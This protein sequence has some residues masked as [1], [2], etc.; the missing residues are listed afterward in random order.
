[1]HPTSAGAA[2]TVTRARRGRAR[3]A[4]L[5]TL[6]LL[7][8]PLALI[9]GSSPAGAAQGQQGAPQVSINPGGGVSL[10]GD[11][12]LK[13]ILNQA[14]G[15]T[16]QDQVWFAN[17][18]Q[19]CCTAGAPM[20]NIGGELF[21]QSGPAYS[22]SNWTSLTVG[23]TTGSTTTSNGTATGSGSVQLTYVA[24]K[25][26]LT[27]TM[28]RTVSYTYPN[29][30]FSDSYSFTIPNGNT[31][32]VKFYLGGDTAPGSSDQGYGIMLTSPVRSVISLNTSSQIQFGYRE[33]GGERAFDG[34]RSGDYWEP[35]AWVQA[36]QDIPFHVDAFD[37][38]AGLMVQWN[39]GSTPGT[40]TGKL[41]QFVTYQ[42][43]SL[44]AQFRHASFDYTTE[45]PFDFNLTNT[46][47]TSAVGQGFTFAFPNGM[48]IGSGSQTNGCGGTVT[49][50]AGSSTVTMSGVDVVATS[51]CVLTIPV[52][53]A[54]PG[55]YA[56]STSSVS[57]L[58]GGIVNRV[59]NSTAAVTSST[60]TPPAWVDET[61][62]A[63]TQGSYYND[64]LVASGW[65]LP[66]FAVTAGTL[67][68]GLSLDTAT[69]AITGTPTT[70]GA[71]S[72]SITASNGQGTDLV[73]S[74]SGTVSGTPVAPSWSDQTLAAP[75]VDVAY[76]DGVAASGYPAVTY[77][78]SAG[79][80]PAG[81]SL[82]ANTGAVTGTPTTPGAY[83]FTIQASNGV[84]SPVTRAFS[85]TVSQ[86]PSF[87]DETLAPFQEGT[88]YADGLSV[89]ATP[90][91]TYTV[92]AGALP[93]GI[94][95]DANTG[96][97]TGTPTAVG[98]YSFTI[99]VSNG[100]APDLVK[101][102]TG[103][104]LPAVPPAVGIDLQLEIGAEPGTDGA[105]ALV[106]G[107]GMLPGSPY[108]VVMHS[109][110]IVLATG[111]VGGDGTFSQY[112]TIP[113]NAPAGSHTL[114]VTGT[115]SAGDPMSD[116]A[117]FAI[118][119]NGT[120]GDV[121]TDVPLSS[122]LGYAGLT[123]ARVLDTRTADP[124]LPFEGG[125]EHELVVVGVGGVP[126]DA[127]SVQLNVTVTGGSSAG[128]VTVYPCG[129]VRPWASNVN[130]V[131]GQTVANGATVAVGTG[132][133]VCIY[134]SATVHVVVDVNGAFSPSTGAG[135]V[136]GLTPARAL[137]TRDGDAVKVAAGTFRAVP[138]AGLHGVATHASSV[139]VNVTVTEPESDG[140]ATVFPCGA[141]VPLAS[142]V[143]FLAGETVPN[144]VTA[145][146]GTD[147]AVCVYTSATAHLVVDVTAEY[148]SD[149]REGHTLDA[150][151]ARLLDTREASGPTEGQPLT[152]GRTIEVLVAG[153]GSIPS[154]AVSATL[155]VTVDGPS[156]SGYVTVFPCGVER[157]L[158]SSVNFVA[159]QTAANTVTVAVGTAGKVCV[160]VS[161]DTHLVVDFDA[162]FGPT[163]VV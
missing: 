84:G 129:G 48:T 98:A 18:V 36:G 133:K 108:E 99:T 54:G 4:M 32:T 154:S 149:N 117:Y 30:Y 11:D 3:R 151:I 140:F 157:P 57:N 24:T 106:Q 26:A 60:N 53:V 107:E 78:V 88:A 70:P 90:A 68:A 104:V 136:H 109:D 146:I 120:I 9:A 6:A 72:F 13:V 118:S 79:A 112:V 5:G 131:A 122:D 58:V 91:A 141:D 20:L 87:T 83:S 114:I 126:A 71:Y 38:D 31:D 23:T 115:S 47:L 92:T 80:L 33:I 61:L 1:M 163:P 156:G 134:T 111:T 155:N 41:E 94:S 86:A 2:G 110:P 101:V 152:A 153:N 76:T 50:V 49:A 66:T 67:P 138:V 45:E 119:G 159:G 143:N 103:M 113:A 34:A 27:Y 150:A 73:K 102:F 21:G 145:A 51:N 105:R 161:N 89:V 85:G 100:T 10:N 95:L 63:I 35:Y 40:T 46:L 43:S 44:S 14:N 22:E 162:G 64:G 59:A 127:T 128:F 62:G 52:V 121:S 130:F 82:D 8:A 97:L 135:R 17:T 16:G 132:G 25:N 147:G 96:A 139:V 160:Y 7:A 137:D 15:S 19:Y 144:A 148:R 12:G 42:E 74:F 55:N 28:V 29:T 37:H 65:P 81:L 123:P 125:S 75:Q 77:T 39:L 124:A 158:A 116:E 93:A 142:N 69:G 56:V